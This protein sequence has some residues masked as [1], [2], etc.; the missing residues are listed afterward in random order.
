VTTARSHSRV[1]RRADGRKWLDRRGRPGP[2]SGR[3]LSARRPVTALWLA[4]LGRH[5]AQIRPI[6]P[7]PPLVP[8]VDP[9]PLAVLVALVRGTAHVEPIEQREAVAWLA[10]R[11]DGCRPCGRW[12]GSDDLTIVLPEVRR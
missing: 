6:P 7:P 3:W 2:V 1:R 10:E 12:V 4:W 8:G 5:W 9:P 11:F